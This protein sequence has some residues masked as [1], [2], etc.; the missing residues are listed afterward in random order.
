[1][2]RKGALRQS[3]G[4]AYG[5]S[6]GSRGRTSTRRSHA[7]G[8]TKDNTL[9]VFGAEEND[10]FDSANVG[11][12]IEPTRGGTPGC[13]AFS[14]DTYCYASGQ[15]GEINTNLP[16]LLAAQRGNATPFAIEPQGAVIYVNGHRGPAIR[17][18]GGSSGISVPSPTRTIRTRA[19]TTSRSRR[20]WPAA[21]NG[22]SCTW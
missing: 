6:I 8:I 3:G 14:A 5:G 20:T 15:I 16:G 10:Q 17:P 2:F 1:V 7:A 13:M 11:R 4:P 19:T 9:F 12:A 22:R 21:S 18:F